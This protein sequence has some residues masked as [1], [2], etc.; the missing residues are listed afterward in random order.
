VTCGNGHA[1]SGG[2]GCGVQP[3]QEY[4][5]RRDQ[6]KLHYH[7]HQNRNNR[8][9]QTSS[10]FTASCTEIVPQSIVIPTYAHFMTIPVTNV[11]NVEYVIPHPPSVALN[12]GPLQDFTT[13]SELMTAM[14]LQF[15][16]LNTHY[17]ATPFQFVW[18][19][20]DN[21]TISTNLNY[22]NFPLDHMEAMSKEYGHP[23]QLTILDIYI[24]YSVRSQDIP[25]TNAFVGYSTFPSYQI[26]SQNG[27]SGDGVFITYDVL[28]IDTIDGSILM[29]EIGHW[30]GLYH[31]FQNG[32]DAHNDFVDDTP[33]HSDSTATSFPTASC[34]NFVNNPVDTCTSLPGNDPVYNIMN[35]VADRSCM[36]TY[37]EIT[38]GQIERMYQQWYLYR[39][40]DNVCNSQQQQP[41][42]LEIF[43]V[44]DKAHNTEDTW[45]LVKESQDGTTTTTTIFDSTSDFADFEVPRR[46][47]ELYMDLCLES[48]NY[49]FILRDAGNNGFSNGAHVDVTLDGTLIQTVTG[50]F[51]S[52]VI[53]PIVAGSTSDSQ[54]TPSPIPNTPSPTTPAPVRTATLVPTTPAPVVRTNA[55]TRSIPDAATTTSSPVPSTPTAKPWWQWPSTKP[56][57][58]TPT[59]A[60]TSMAPSTTLPTGTPT[61]YPRVWNIV[62]SSSSSQNDAPA[63][64]SSSSSAA[65]TR[66]RTVSTIV[67]T[68]MAGWIVSE[69]M[70]A[71]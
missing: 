51:G 13:L 25:A 1:G 3:P 67:A 38:C 4:A 30:L 65:T 9:L 18:Q 35:Y 32:C 19:N 56:P 47:D 36:G 71:L 10:S 41:H 61:K 2:G 15:Q 20:R 6:A 69:C 54:T 39:Q 26:G 66:I 24:S 5:L 68:L 46:Q 33:A 29:H 11:P 58:T 14:D 22:T 40:T 23:N 28:P 37:A 52:Q 59:V 16:I 64:T 50:N 17:S 70:F 57:T 63:A 31:T 42:H 48:G 53:I 44:F 49:Q 55:P 45:A 60:P 12:S 21:P 7:R 34:T 62:S 43:I 27:G 8:H